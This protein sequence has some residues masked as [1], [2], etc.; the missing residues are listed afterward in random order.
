MV[1]RPETD[2]IVGHDH[3]D[4]LASDVFG[5]PGCVLDGEGF[6]GQNRIELLVDA[7][8]APR[9]PFR[10]RARFE[11]AGGGKKRKR[12]DRTEGAADV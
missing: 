10:S 9:P 4:A 5:W 6:W 12:L 2:E 8:K 1:P 3:Q 7:L 11:P